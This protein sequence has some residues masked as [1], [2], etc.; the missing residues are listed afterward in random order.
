MC[1]NWCRDVLCPLGEAGSVRGVCKSVLFQTAQSEVHQ[2]QGQDML[3]KTSAI[4]ILCLTAVA[5]SQWMS[6]SWR[7][8]V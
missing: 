7:K 1:V 2:P 8:M 5:E 3:K 6:H 4:Y